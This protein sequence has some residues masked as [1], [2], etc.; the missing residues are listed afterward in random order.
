MHRRSVIATKKRI[1]GY[2]ERKSSLSF[3]GDRKQSRVAALDSSIHGSRRRSEDGLLVRQGSLSASIHDGSVNIDAAAAA[4]G[5]DADLGCSRH[6]VDEG[7]IRVYGRRYTITPSTIHGSSSNLLI[8]Q[9]Q[10]STIV[11][12][13][14]GALT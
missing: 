6:S 7:T 10:S 13:N 3:G 2:I 9:R 14:Q 12:N 5:A 1:I 4:T 8:L 11:H